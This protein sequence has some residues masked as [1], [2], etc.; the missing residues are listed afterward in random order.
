[1]KGVMNM[2]VTTEP[3]QTTVQ[4]W[5]SIQEAADLLGVSI[6]TLRRWCR[7]GVVPTHRLGP[8]LLRFDTAELLAWAA[9][10][11]R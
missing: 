6:A 4:P 11:P 8:R 2:N 9:D 3:Q 5:I 10:Q 7:D 1:M